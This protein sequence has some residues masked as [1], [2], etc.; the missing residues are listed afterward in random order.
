[1]TVFCL[2]PLF[3]FLV[4]MLPR[5]LAYV[6]GPHSLKTPQFTQKAGARV[7]PEGL[8]LAGSGH[9]IDGDPKA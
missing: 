4:P 8:R 9:G 5:K 3:R 1:M 6:G 2:R 7:P